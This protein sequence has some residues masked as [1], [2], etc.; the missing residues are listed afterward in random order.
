[1]PITAERLTE[2][3]TVY[4]QK[5]AEAVQKYPQEY[6]F[7][8]SDVPAVAGRMIVAFAKG[9]YNKNSHAIKATCKHFGIKHTYQAINKW[10]NQE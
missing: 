9:S 8:V 5:L 7:P 6:G 4:E 10:L 1:M 2:W 3:R